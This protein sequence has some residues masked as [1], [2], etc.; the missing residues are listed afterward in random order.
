MRFHLK[1]SLRSFFNSIIDFIY[2]PL[3]LSCQRLL[4]HGGDYVCPECWNAIPVVRRGS[5]LY[6]DTA[7]K[8]LASGVVDDLISLYVFEK[9]GVFQLIA[10]NL[11]YSGVQALGLELGRRLGKIV[12]EQGIRADAIIPV[13]LHRRKLRERGYN[14]AE[15]IG[16][17]VSEVTGI[18]VNANI[19]RRAKYTTT[20]TTLSL[21]E[22]QKNMEGAFEVTPGT[23]FQTEGKIFIVI[24]DVITTGATIVACAAPLCAHGAASV[25]GGSS[26]LAE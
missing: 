5:S 4:E 19:V 6:S 10:H 21:E 20:Q 26:A 18:P 15:L 17:G 23:E 8:L 16:T 9:E 24:D 12:M 2:P 22:R 13:P 25:I 14:Q 11:K 7:D 3:C 1:G